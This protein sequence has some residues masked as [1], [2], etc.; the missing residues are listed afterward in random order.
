[1]GQGTPQVA[2][3]EGLLRSGLDL[4]LGHKSVVF[5]VILNKLKNLFHV[6]E[7]VLLREGRVPSTA[8]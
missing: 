2:A 4:Y 3:Q 6:L 5:S 1:M 8:K 7:G